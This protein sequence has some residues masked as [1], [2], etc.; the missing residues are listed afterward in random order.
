MERSRSLIA[1][2]ARGGPGQEP[3]RGSSRRRRSTMSSATS[4]TPRPRTKACARMSASASSTGTRNCTATIPEAWCTTKRKLPR[5]ELDGDRPRCR[6]R[7]HR[8]DRPSRDGR[9]HEGVGVLLLRQRPGTVAVQ[10]HRPDC[11]VTDREWEP[12]HRPRPGGH[13]GRAERGPP[14]GCRVGEIRFGDCDVLAVGVDAR[15]LAERVLQLLDAGA[16][17]VGRADRALRLIIGEQ[18]D[19]GAVDIGD[20]GA[21]R[22]QAG[23]VSGA[24][25]HRESGQD[26]DQ[27]VRRHQ[28]LPAGDGNTRDRPTPVLSRASPRASERCGPVCSMLQPLQRGKRSAR[29]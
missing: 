19:P 22:A 10:V 23:P 24:V 16:D 3:S 14:D 6:R 2:Y 4:A 25:L 11:G 12:E 13:G 18:H 28:R 1:W 15:P 21:D 27:P 5:V 29:A 7:L 8:Q 26:A 9:H 17:V 20:L